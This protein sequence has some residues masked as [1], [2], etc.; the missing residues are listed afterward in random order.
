MRYFLSDF[1]R[2]GATFEPME[3]L[4]VSPKKVEMIGNLVYYDKRVHVKIR[5]SKRGVSRVVSVL[6][7][8]KETAIENFKWL[9][10]FRKSAMQKNMNGFRDI[11][12]CRTL[13]YCCWYL[14]FFLHLFMIF[15]ISGSFVYTNKIGLSLLFL[16]AVLFSFSRLC[17]NKWKL[18]PYGANHY[19]C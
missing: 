11:V 18:I 4:S 13:S 15:Y 16:G 12:K 1:I 19:G 17:R 5:V 10:D 8:E 6:D 3:I 2:L 9:H 14:C 7:N